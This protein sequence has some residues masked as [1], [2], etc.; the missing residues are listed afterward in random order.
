MCTYLTT[1]LTLLSQ[2]RCLSLLGIACIL[3]AL[4]APRL[5]LDYRRQ[6][7]ELAQPLSQSLQT[8][9][10]LKIHLIDQYPSGGPIQFLQRHI[11]LWTLRFLHLPEENPLMWFAFFGYSLAMLTLP[12]FRAEFIPADTTENVRF[13]TFYLW[14][15]LFGNEWI[16]LADTWKFAT[17][18][19][20]FNVGVFLM[21]FAWK[22]T[23][24][25]DIHCCGSSKGRK[26]VRQL[27]EHAWFKGLEILYWLWRASDVTALASFYGGIWPTLILNIVVLW[28]CFLGV[29]LAFGLHNHQRMQRVGHLVEVC[30]ACQEA[31]QLRPT[32]IS[33]GAVEAAQPGGA[34]NAQTITTHIERYRQHHPVHENPLIPSS[35]SS[36]SASASSSSSSS[37]SNS[38]RNKPSAKQD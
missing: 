11:L 7:A 14:G 18:Q 5:Y 1:L 36:S 22:A 4:L 27:N 26:G 12:W 6:K 24:S 3:F 37:P 31:I 10:I 29:M 9:I 33:E 16:P 35:S 15:I 2:L 20:C 32:D 13:G 28:L 25:V 30:V 38:H 17:V 23:H 21:L 8:S 34:L 19:I